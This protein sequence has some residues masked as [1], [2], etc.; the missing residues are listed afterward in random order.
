MN[1]TTNE[2]TEVSKGILYVRNLVFSVMVLISIIGLSGIVI[3]SDTETYE[4]G[5]DTNANVSTN[6]SIA[7]FGPYLEAY[8]FVEN[9]KQGLGNSTS[10]VAE[11]GDTLTFTLY[12][13]NTGTSPAYGVTV[14]DYLP[15]GF[16]YVPGSIVYYECNGTNTTSQN[17]TRFN[18]NL[19]NFP[20]TFMND[21][22][23]VICSFTK[24]NGANSTTCLDPGA[25]AGTSN[26]T[27]N[28]TYF[29]YI[30]IMFDAN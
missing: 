28:T 3:A 8:K 9:P 19:I 30:K 27:I 23:E 4:T 10:E 5:S 2:R 1:T 14:I 22:R 13:V 11:V 17:C 29:N 6:F 12:A 15:E 21:S 25:P 7:S 18:Y 26:K 16:D 20:C 24:L